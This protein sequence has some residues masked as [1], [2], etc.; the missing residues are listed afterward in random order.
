MIYEHQQAVVFFLANSSHFAKKIRPGKHRPKDFWKNSIKFATFLAP[1]KKN[2]GRFLASF[3][4]N[5]HI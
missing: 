2:L 5:S 4:K 3:L 1:R